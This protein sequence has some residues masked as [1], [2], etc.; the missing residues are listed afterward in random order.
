MED[1]K[2]VVGR[3]NRTDMRG[4]VYVRA[5]FGTMKPRWIWFGAALVAP[6][7]TQSDGDV[8]IDSTTSNS[9]SSSSSSSSAS[10]SSCESSRPSVQQTFVRMQRAYDTWK[11]TATHR[12]AVQIDML[13]R[14]QLVDTTGHGGLLIK[15]WMGDA[16]IDSTDAG[17]EHLIQLPYLEHTTVRAV[18]LGQSILGSDAEHDEY[19]VMSTQHRFAVFDVADCLAAHNLGLF[20]V[21]ESAPLAKLIAVPTRQEYAELEVSRGVSRAV[22][23]QTLEEAQSLAGT[24]AAALNALPASVPGDARALMQSILDDC[25]KAFA[26]QGQALAG[27]VA[28]AA[29]TVPS[30]ATPA[31]ATLPADA[32]D[33]T[34]VVRR[35]LVDYD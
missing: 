18:P 20:L 11:S 33:S 19:H 12:P 4:M 16:P 17:Q 15:L 21:A 14:S 26:A 8:D 30:E 31:D 35:G 29:A 7:P 10:P 5:F 3:I 9:S 22:V 25:I 32:P 13:G 34:T 27:S 24:W 2:I 6:K 23:P 1:D 28:A